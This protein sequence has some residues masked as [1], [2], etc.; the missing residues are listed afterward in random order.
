MTKAVTEQCR[1]RGWQLITADG[2]G[3]DFAGYQDCAN[4]SYLGLPRAG[5]GAAEEHRCLEALV[6]AHRILTARMDRRATGVSDQHSGFTPMLLVLNE[7]AGLMTQWASQLSPEQL[8]QVLSMVE[9]LLHAGASVRCHVLIVPA[10]GWNWQVPR[11][12][13]ALCTA[14]FLGPP[15]KGD[16]VRF[17]STDAIL[18]AGKQMSR[19]HKG[20]GMLVTPGA[21]EIK[22][23]QTFWTYS[24]GEEIG[25]PRSPAAVKDHWQQFKDQVCDRTPALYPKLHLDRREMTQAGT[26][27][28]DIAELL[29]L[30]LVVEDQPG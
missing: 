21:L 18:R 12:W 25:R 11:G 17:A 9:D 3:T 2:K 19:E 30:P 20:L 5:I 13:N 7:F 29:S 15:N 28:L 24:P 22:L 27:E 6:I 26:A 14:V 23:F 8:R 4:V 1:T 10:S 16:A